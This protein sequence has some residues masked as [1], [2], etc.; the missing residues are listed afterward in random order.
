M[1]KKYLIFIFKIFILFYFPTFIFFYEFV[2]FIYTISV[3]TKPNGPVGLFRESS[4][5][6]LILCND[7]NGPARPTRAKRLCWE[8]SFPFLSGLDFV[9]RGP[10]PRVRAGP[11]VEPRER[12]SLQSF[13]AGLKGIGFVLFPTREPS[14]RRWHPPLLAWLAPEEN[15]LGVSTSRSPHVIKQR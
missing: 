7:T 1:E 9:A 5:V 8:V 10:H 12:E 2:F 4:G 6:Q 14:R 13:V 11:T 3:P 15:L